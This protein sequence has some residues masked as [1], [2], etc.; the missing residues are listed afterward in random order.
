[1]YFSN[2]LI[3]NKPKKT[4]YNDSPS[5]RE[6]NPN[7]IFKPSHYFVTATL[8]KPASDAS[9]QAA[10]ADFRARG[11]TIQNVCRCSSKTNDDEVK[12]SVREEIKK[13]EVEIE[14]K[15]RREN[16]KKFYFTEEGKIDALHPFNHQRISVLFS[17]FSQSF[18][19][20]STFCVTPSVL[21][22]DFYGRNDI[23]LGAFLERYCFN[24]TYKCLSAICTAPFLHHVRKFVHGSG[25]IEIL[26][27]QMESSLDEMDSTTIYMW[28][29]CKLCRQVSPVVPMSSDTWTFSFAKYLEFRFQESKINRR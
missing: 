10:L 12:L 11:G 23:N 4:E 5:K 16:L 8:T 19:F 13:L 25:C 18:H 24:S 26:L 14:E 15:K 1:M 7:V 6:D 28:S 17:S 27:R 2:S 22:M 20:N 9:V 3:P 21:T 29:W